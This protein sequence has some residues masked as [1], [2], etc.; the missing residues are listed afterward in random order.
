MNYNLILVGTGTTDHT[1]ATYTSCGV[2]VTDGGIYDCDL[3]GRFLKL[4][5][6][7]NPQ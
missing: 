4:E 2:T 3:V 6:D 5:Q 7:D 1:T